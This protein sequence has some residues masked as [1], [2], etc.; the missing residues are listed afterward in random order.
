MISEIGAD[1]ETIVQEQLANVRT[2]LGDIVI[3]LFGD[4]APRAVESF[5]SLAQSGYY[6][7]RGFHRLA[8]GLLIRTGG[9][10]GESIWAGGHLLEDELIAKELPRHDEPYTVSMASLNKGQLF[11]SLRELAAEF[12]DRQVVFGR[13]V[14]GQ[15][16]V[17]AIGAK[18][19][20]ADRPPDVKIIKVLVKSK[21]YKCL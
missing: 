18:N 20:E 5:R 10:P 11:I 1:D 21:Y 19:P 8:P 14:S 13:V 7:G 15:E 12:D 9:D 6:N 3:E 2:S 16:I 4:E 17:D